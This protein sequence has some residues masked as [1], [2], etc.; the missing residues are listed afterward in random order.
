MK[1]GPTYSVIGMRQDGSEVVVASGLSHEDACVTRDLLCMSD[2]SL[3]DIRAEPDPTA[4]SG[5]HRTL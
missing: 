2:K 4:D 3:I 1:P 5:Q